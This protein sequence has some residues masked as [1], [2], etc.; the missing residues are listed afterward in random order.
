MGISTG[1]TCYSFP[2]TF[3]GNGPS[4]LFLSYL[5]HGNVP[6]YDPTTHGPHPDPVLHSKLTQIGSGRPLYDALDS[7]KTAETLTEH[8][9]SSTFMSY[10]SQALPI[11]VLLDTLVRPN[12]DTEIGESKSRIRWERDPAR[13]VDH[14]V[15]GDAGKAGGQWAEDAI[16]ANWDCETLRFVPKISHYPP[17][18]MT[19]RVGSSSYAE[20]LS[21][22]GYSFPD[23][24]KRTHRRA[25]QDL[26]R[27]TR[28]EV[29][30]YYSAY[31]K[32]VGISSE[33][34]TSV[35]AQRVRQLPQGGFELRVSHRSS[36]T[37]SSKT[38]TIICT[39]LVLA[40]GIYSHVIPPPPIFASLIHNS[41]NSYTTNPSAAPLLVVGSGFTAADVM[42]AAKDAG[43]KICHIYKWDPTH[44][45][46]LKGCHPQAYPEYAQIYRRMKAV[47]STANSS[48]KSPSPPADDGYEGFPNARVISASN[49]GRIR[50]LTADG[51][52]VE[53]VVGGLKYCVG[54][55][56][57]LEYLSPELRKAVGVVD[58]GWISGDTM[59]WRVE[60]DLEVVKGVFVV[61]SLTG[62]S[63]VR[64]G[65]GGCTYAAGK[66][67]GYKTEES[68]KNGGGREEAERGVEAVDVT[69]RT[70]C[71]IT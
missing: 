29:A 16:G 14:L 28:R 18:Y 59:R 57:S 61:G 42:I 39:H 3:A 19:E 1:F 45:S 38:M 20:L 68:R 50:I 40:T 64:F 6:I 25:M 67:L 10:S 11:N 52:I 62:D 48:L 46:P 65:F 35:H 66:I 63:L 13:R 15:L 31:P 36:S 41:N 54:R 17:R 47:I 8:F 33:V 37:S 26:V 70:S 2:L 71:V 21:L 24:C 12:A 60:E 51:D 23:H 34:F 9:P 27:P 53:R 69:R 55:R 4:A 56:G 30:A 43:R 44:P 49:D 7:P 58:A 22:P 5:L 32:A